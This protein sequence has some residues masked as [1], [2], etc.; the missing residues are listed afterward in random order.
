MLSLPFFKK[1]NLEDSPWAV[2][3]LSPDR[4]S[5]LV[6]KNSGQNIEVLGV[7]YAPQRTSDMR[8][9]V[10][11]DL[12][13]VAQNSRAALDQAVYSQ[14]IDYPQKAVL[15]TGAEIIR[16]VT[17]KARVNRKESEQP[18]TEE[19]WKKIETRLTVAA[20]QK[21]LEEV[22]QETGQQN[23][24][25][26]EL[27]TWFSHV[28]LD[29]FEITN[30]VGFRGSVLEVALFYQAGVKT[31]LSAVSSVASFLKFRKVF[32]TDT[33]TPLLL[34]DYRDQI[35]VNDRGSTTEVTVQ[36]N[37]AIIGTKV[38]PLG[39]SHLRKENGD[40]LD[41]WASSLELALEG[42]NASSY[43]F[44][45]VLVTDSDIELPLRNK[46]AE[47]AREDT[48]PIQQEG[49]VEEVR[50]LDPEE[51]VDRSGKLGK[52]PP[53]LFGLM[54]FALFKSNG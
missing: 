33:N 44:R 19:E 28:L 39:S 3:D 43:P 35:F 27:A 15:G 37:R 18:I 11:A 26:E 41:W 42:F 17:V 8:S 6:F 20:A 36:I 21:C 49:A 16:H 2:I 45:F 25:L 13:A 23:I 12:S 29:G 52:V 50:T 53:T 7:G 30:P 5:A 32:I 40:L 46:L 1:A 47:F 14:G 51:M 34:N 22:V 38:I 54:D 4:V 10:I 31:H 24:K 9:G 48:L